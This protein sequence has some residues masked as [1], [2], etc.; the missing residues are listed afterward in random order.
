MRAY[1]YQSGGSSIFRYFIFVITIVVLVGV[2][3]LF[4][5]TPSSLSSPSASNDE[6]HGFTTSLRSSASSSSSSSR[7]NIESK[8]TDEVLSDHAM[9]MQTTQPKVWFKKDRPD[10]NYAPELPVTYTCS[11]PLMWGTDHRG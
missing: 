3:N 8:I 9:S 10:L 2:Y 7:A 4:G 5:S 11:T 6:G 1:P